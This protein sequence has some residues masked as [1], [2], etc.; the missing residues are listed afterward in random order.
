L[1]KEVLKCANDDSEIS[2][3]K[4]ARVTAEYYGVELDDIK[5]DARGQKVSTARHM[6]V[7]LSREITNKSFASI[8][9]YFEKKH[10]SIMFGHDKVKKELVVNNELSTVVREIKQALKLI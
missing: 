2:L 3:D 1:V 5:G 9:E 6:A 8:A 7:Y 4:I 10:T